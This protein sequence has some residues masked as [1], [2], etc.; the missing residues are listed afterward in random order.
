MRGMTRS[1]VWMFNDI[2]SDNVWMF[3]RLSPLHVDQR[4]TKKLQ[5]IDADFVECHDVTYNVL[6]KVREYKTNINRIH[7][8]LQVQSHGTV[9]CMVQSHGT[10]TWY[11]HMAAY[12]V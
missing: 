10:A 4:I 6:K 9:T 8:G 7:T 11:S 12:R 3:Y 1:K 5:Q 2:L